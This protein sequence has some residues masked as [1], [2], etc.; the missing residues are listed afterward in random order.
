MN[1]KTF[2]KLLSQNESK[3]LN[4]EYSSNEFVPGNY[5]ITEIKNHQITSVDCGGN[6]HD[7]KQTV[8]QLWSPDKPE[9]KET[10]TANKAIKIFKKVAELQA[11]NQDAEI[12]FEYGKGNLKTS[13]YKV[14]KIVNGDS[15]LKLQLFVE[16]TACKPRLNAGTSGA[17]C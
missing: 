3:A 5:H 7:F 11:M 2:L 14:R 15:E 10:F 9:T 17:C 8:V 13:I 12:L 1:T 16:P 4:F 6:A